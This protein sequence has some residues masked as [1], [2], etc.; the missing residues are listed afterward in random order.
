LD[1]KLQV[2]KY[3]PFNEVISFPDVGDLSNVSIAGTSSILKPFITFTT[4]NLTFASDTGFQAASSTKEPLILTTFGS[5]TF[6]NNVY[7]GNGRFFPP[8]S[9]QAF[10]FYTNEPVST[11]LGSDI[12]FKTIAEMY[13]VY[14]TPSLPQGLSFSTI[15]SN[16]FLLGGTPVIGS[17]PK[18]YLIIGQNNTSGKVV[19]TSVNIGVLGERLIVDVPTYSST[20]S[21]GT[22]IIPGVFTAKFPTYGVYSFGFTWSNT[23]PDGL[24]L[25]DNAGNA[26]P[27][28]VYKYIPSSAPFS[29]GISGTPTTNAAYSYAD[30][31]VSTSNITILALQSRG[32]KTLSNKIELTMPFSETILFRNI[33][34]S[35]LYKNS[36]INSKI[37][38]VATY[39]SNTSSPVN[40][41]PTSIEDGSLAIQQSLN[42]VRIVGTPLVIDSNVY[43]FNA[44][45]TNQ[46]TSS[47]NVPIII[48]EDVIV[49]DY[50]V[51]PSN[52]S[53]YNF[54]ISRPVENALDG[55]YTYPIQ[56]LARADS[57]SPITYSFSG[58]EN[59]GL[60]ITNGII[61]GTPTSAYGRSEIYINATAKNTGVFAKTTIVVEIID[62]IF[63]VN[64]QT[65]KFIQNQTITPYQITSTTLSGR[66][67]ISHA[68]IYGIP[69]GIKISPTGLI[70]GTPIVAVPN[71]S[72][73]F[74]EIGTGYRSTTIGYDYFINEDIMLF[75]VSK[76]SYSLVLG[77]NIPQIQVGAVTYSGHST[78]NFLIKNSDP[79]ETT[80]GITI[81]SDKGIIGGTLASGYPPILLKDAANLEI[82]TNANF[83]KGT[84]I[85]TLLTENPPVITK[86]FILFG[87]TNTNMYFSD[88]ETYTSWNIGFKPLQI[89]NNATDIQISG[90]GNYTNTYMVSCQNIMGRSTD[91][92][93]FQSYPI[94]YTSPIASPGITKSTFTDDF[95]V[96][97]TLWTCTNSYGTIKF[98]YEISN[99]NC[100]IV[101]AG[102]GGGGYNGGGGGGAGNIVTTTFL[103]LNAGTYPIR[104][105]L[106]GNIG[107]NGKDSTFNNI[108]SVG[109]GSGGTPGFPGLKGACGGGGS[110][111][112]S[113]G[114]G[115]FGGNGAA[116]TS[117]IA[118]GGGGMGGT[119][120]DDTG[121]VNG[122]IDVP[123]GFP[124]DNQFSAGGGINSMSGMFGSG[125]KSD[126]P[127]LN[128]IVYIYYPTPI[129]GP[130][131]IYKT[132]NIGNGVWVGAGIDTTLPSNIVFRK[133]INDGISWNTGSYV[134]NENMLNL[135]PRTD[136]SSLN[137]NYYIKNALAMAYSPDAN[138]L[139]IG[140]WNQGAT[141]GPMLRSSNLGET[142]EEVNNGLSAEVGDYSLEN[143]NTWIVTGSDNYFTG[144]AVPSIKFPYCKTMIYS[145]DSGLNWN[146]CINVFNYIAY[147]VVY[148]GNIWVAL[149]VDI[150]Q[151]LQGFIF[152]TRA[153]YSKDGVLWA[154]IDAFSVLLESNPPPSYIGMGP[155]QF[156][157]IN[158]K[159]IL[160]VNSGDHIVFYEHSAGNLND[161]NW[162]NTNLW[163]S[164]I[165]YKSLEAVLY[166]GESYK[167][168]KDKNIGNIPSPVSEWWQISTIW[169]P[170]VTYMPGDLVTYNF[171]TYIAKNTSYSDIPLASDNWRVVFFPKNTKLSSLTKP[172]YVKVS[173]STSATLV[174]PNI[175]ISGGPTFT[176]P[177]ITQYRYYQYVK[178]EPVTISA[179]GTDNVYIFIR[180]QDVPQGLVFDPA[181]GLLY[182]TPT[183]PVENHVIPVYAKDSVGVSQLNI[184]ITIV[185]PFIMKKQIGAA[186]YTSAV[187]QNVEINAAQN[188]RDNKVTPNHDIGLGKLMS[189]APPDV[190]TDR[191]CPC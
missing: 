97:Y 140:G 41:T 73:M 12:L 42:N 10:M 100:I 45:N 38:D 91:G 152:K 167:S 114:I 138:V 61:S 161:G 7:I 160:G 26:L 123:T 65:F 191:P 149:G 172:K 46:K 74:I 144:Q 184:V 155:I 70:S 113:G 52:G 177:T 128:G 157:D 162:I 22:P 103:S 173:S 37:F 14:S 175:V 142:W 189:P 72:R 89:N 71:G 116:G 11:T 6:S 57:G 156:D 137:S 176:S 179:S 16:N 180:D 27:S 171:G 136:P 25:T 130:T 153:K 32:T 19:T 58:L 110:I 63:N 109:G 47:V 85:A 86:N 35:I 120:I 29:I 99:V 186:A 132:A 119:S 59:T 84:L 150:L 124:G 23:I 154:T 106:G 112:N 102:G 151:G 54:V 5:N 98:P 93:T 127:G 68:G 8:S 1:G 24:Y 174:F 165:L 134:L 181:T 108:I 83:L 34:T 159:W 141:A 182:G 77:E 183:L 125:G 15:D 66:P 115:L 105:G 31:G 17:S 92:L 4:S 39:F 117:L 90:D 2:Y 121:G 185:I 30:A 96:N 118:G 62:D 169:N 164:S 145:Y 51:T 44:S 64:P 188:A 75:I 9:N 40:V 28:N 187:R 170:N 67:V 126:S 88:H 36:Y 190:I 147:S 101:G 139:M 143:P 82:T 122:I 43:T 49:F 158:N 168:I 78:S 111:N 60:T 21:I 163:N 129:E 178:I 79:E 50:S 95:G 133:S 18:N 131:F 146:N 20:L 33:S 87:E 107:E 56:F 13:N 76:T 148:G 104:V 135:S 69:P 166:D 48:K 80:Y 3:E 53:Y 55:Y 94:N 81:D